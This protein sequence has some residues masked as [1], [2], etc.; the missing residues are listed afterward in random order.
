MMS[1]LNTVKS[2][3]KQLCVGWDMGNLGFAGPLLMYLMYPLDGGR[4]WK[5]QLLYKQCYIRID[6]IT[7]WQ[8]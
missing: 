6:Y 2:L 8:I 3:N 5:T 1:A 7:Y 4:E